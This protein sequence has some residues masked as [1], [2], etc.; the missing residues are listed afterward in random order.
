MN[1]AQA[2]SDHGRSVIVD[3]LKAEIIGP[4]P[5]GEPLKLDVN[6]H[7]P[8]LESSF[9]PW[10]DAA[11]GEEILNDPRIG[12]MRR[13][14]SGVL[15]PENQTESEVVFDDAPI[16]DPEEQDV[17]EVEQSK[18][19]L[20]KVADNDANDYALSSANELDPRSAAISFVVP[21]IG[22]TL[23]VRV[24]GAYYEQFTVTVDGGKK[25]SSQRAWYVRRP[26]EF[27]A[28][29]TLNDGGGNETASKNSRLLL[30]ETIIH[31]QLTSIA[32]CVACPGGQKTLRPSL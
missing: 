31:Y 17:I 3:A 19:R 26:I 25:G 22:T 21:E 32:S 11:T 20:V 8:N 23:K 9:G 18:R 27:R 13:Y 24:S 6:P 4:D 29:L 30:R 16:V 5:A 1:A 15:F 12:P 14:A 10:V 7:F 28:E 2:L